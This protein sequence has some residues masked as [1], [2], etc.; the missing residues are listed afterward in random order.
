MQASTMVLFVICSAVFVSYGWG[1]RGTII[2]GEKGAMLPGAIMGLMIALFSG[3]SVLRQNFFM[4]SA[5]GSMGMF[6]GGAMTYGETLGLSMNQK[7]AENMKKGLVALFIKGGVW[8]GNF[9]AF[10]GI[11]LSTAAGNRY[12]VKDISLL[13]GLIP[14]FAIIWYMLLNK[15][16][17]P[18]H[19]KTPKIFFSKTRQEAW[20]GLYGILLV[21]AIMMFTKKDYFAL[22]LTLGAY[23]S[24][25]FGWV[26]AQCL[27]IF[28]KWPMKNGKYFFSYF[29][30]N[31]MLDPWKIMECTLGFVG[32]GG[33][34][35]T[36]CLLKSDY[37]AILN[38][39]N[40]NGIVWNPL[41]NRTNFAVVI[42]VV[43]LALDMLQ[44]IIKKPL[45]RS[46]LD[47]RLEK[48]LINKDSYDKKIKKVK[49]GKPSNFFKYYKLLVEGFENPLFCFLPL[50]A[51][52]L[53][54]A[55]V[56]KLASFFALYHVMVQEIVFTEFIGLKIQRFIQ[57]LTVGAG[58]AIVAAQFIWH[59]SPDIRLTLVMYGLY[60]EG[61]TWLQIYAR[62][63]PN[64]R[65]KLPKPERQ[66]FVKTYKSNFPTQGY[67]TVICIIM[68]VFA[69]T[70]IK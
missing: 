65:K 13:F 60:Y 27:Q 4:L 10:I 33:I 1:M 46:E 39:I 15:P 53:G 42:W 45:S 24:G 70:Y 66:G 37:S 62:S 44:F 7:P 51:V 11:Y 67:F 2:G 22:K 52:M 21:L 5:V 64:E 54:N 56:A 20:G 35:L 55:E 50:F 31:K 41:Q 30:K 59:W 14:V 69:Y 48:S 9:G 63:K 57:I 47:E 29:Q 28:A 34:A 38:L 6:W 17:D 32:G 40:I 61:M 16:H 3:S 58:I 12:N 49:D 68:A 23:L 19:G 26:L 36:L 25:A 18:K 8:F 43:M